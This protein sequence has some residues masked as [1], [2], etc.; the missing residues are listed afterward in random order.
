MVARIPDYGFRPTFTQ[1]QKILRARPD[2]IFHINGNDFRVISIN[3]D[4]DGTLEIWFN[5]NLICMRD[6]K[7][8]FIDVK[9][10]PR[11]STWK[12]V[13]VEQFE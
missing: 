5:S 10:R 3:H 8:N 6:D 2:N 9:K 13:R 1:K 11:G 12:S 4:R 7:V